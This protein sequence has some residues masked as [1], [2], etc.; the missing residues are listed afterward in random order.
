MV[1]ILAPE[2]LN[3]AKFGVTAENKTARILC[4]FLISNK[5][6]QVKCAKLFEV[7][8]APRMHSSDGRVTGP[9]RDMERGGR[10]EG[11]SWVRV[12]AS[13]IPKSINGDAK[14]WKRGNIN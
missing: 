4:T 7:F 2:Q 10:G 1:P 6:C 11:E 9:K 5:A 13:G 3:R 8:Y 14:S 12:G